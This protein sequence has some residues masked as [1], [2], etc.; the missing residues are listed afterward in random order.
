M[1]RAV[2]LAALLIAAPLPAQNA[3]HD[4]IVNFQADDREM[5]A[6]KEEGRRTLPRFFNALA[7]P[8]A[9]ESDFYLKFDLTPDSDPEFIWA[10]NIEIGGDTIRGTL[11]NAPRAEGYK[12][13]DRLIIDRD[14]IVD[15]GFVKDGVM[16][17]NYTTRVVLKTLP[18][19]D[20]AAIRASLGW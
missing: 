15:W 1:L 12:L 17:G 13:G 11:A 3:E 7:N 14:L 10:D 5:N 20:A 16:Q 2:A 4:P 9:G 18:A 6:A 8:A 19:E